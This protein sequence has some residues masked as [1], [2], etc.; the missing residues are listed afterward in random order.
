MSYGL[1]ALPSLACDSH[2]PSPLAALSAQPHS[3]PASPLYAPAARTS[4]D[5]DSA[6]PASPRY[7]SHRRD[8]VASS[9]SSDDD[10]APK[11]ARASPDL[12]WLSR[13][14]APALARASSSSSALPTLASRRAASPA[15]VDDA[16]ADDAARDDEERDSAP[17]TP[18]PMHLPRPKTKGD[19]ERE[20]A[21][22]LNRAAPG[23]KR[24]GLGMKLA[25]KRADSLKWAKYANVGT[26]QVELGLSNDDL[27]RS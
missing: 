23:Q 7:G 12:S 3:A 14:A 22:G 10:A 6:D 17:I 26:F 25:R 19:R 18:L 21:L 24:E 11:P 9:S 15:S 20:R 2:S 27:K 16:G 5:D 8:S 1:A 4:D 13:A